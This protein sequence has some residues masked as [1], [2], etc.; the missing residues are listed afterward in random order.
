MPPSSLPPGAPD[1]AMGEHERHGSTSLG[2]LLGRWAS[3]AMLHPWVV[4]TFTAMVTVL[5]GM[6]AIDLRVD[7]DLQ[8]LLPD[9]APQAERMRRAVQKTGD[10]GY[11]GIVLEADSVLQRDPNPDDPEQ[12]D[13]LRAPNPQAVALAQ[14]L[15]K[16]LRSSPMVRQVVFE[17]PVE[18]LQ[19]NA[20]VLLPLQQLEELHAQIEYEKYKSSPF[21]IEEEEEEQPSDELE[22]LR[23]RYERLQALTPYQTSADRRLLAVRVLPTN[24]VTNVR[25]V[26]KLHDFIRVQLAELRPQFPEVSA[27][28]VGGSLRN[29]LDEYSVVLSDVS[30]SAALGGVLIL[31]LL[32]LYYRNLTT[33]WLTLGC[34][35]M[36]LLWAAAIV[37]LTLG[38]LYIPIP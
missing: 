17:N 27:T 30:N 32:L 8:R 6:S 9:D 23:K 38:F 2:S 15:S 33:T 31:L 24:A 4:L 3:F 37:N 20:F 26:R 18:F 11:F 29:R 19:D 34:A 25:F 35:L 5:C 21:Y 1:D 13:R 28:H 14:E 10:L 16:R 7:T 36:G 22:A 12:K